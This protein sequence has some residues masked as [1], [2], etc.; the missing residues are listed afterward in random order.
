MVEGSASLQMGGTMGIGK[1]V[2]SG[3]AAL[4]DIGCGE[5]EAIF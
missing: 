3:H 1:S 2:R 4:G 5:K